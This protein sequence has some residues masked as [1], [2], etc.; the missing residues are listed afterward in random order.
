MPEGTRSIG[1]LG[2]FGTAL[3]GKEIVT[4]EAPNARS[5]IHRRAHEL[6]G[7]TLESAEAYGKHLLLT[8]SGDR[9][10]HS[11][12]GMNGRWFVRADGRRSYGRPWLELA[13]GPA[14]ANQNGGKILRLDERLPGPQRPGAPPARPRP[15]PPGLRPEEATARLLGYEPS[16]PVGEALLDQTPDRRDRQRDPDRGLLPAGDQPLAADRRPERRGGAGRSS[17]PPPG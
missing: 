2:A 5:P 16:V 15:A 11:H 3:V 10:V 14:I 6:S 9:V 8:F 17:T 13:N 1:S 4:A 12:L 7:R